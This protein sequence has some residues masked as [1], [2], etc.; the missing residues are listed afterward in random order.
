M[1]KLPPREVIVSVFLPLGPL[2]QGMYTPEAF[3]PPKD[4]RIP[5]A[6]LVLEAEAPFNLANLS[7]WSGFCP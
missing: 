3:L 7:P 6:K 5:T 1:Y 2:G 4:T